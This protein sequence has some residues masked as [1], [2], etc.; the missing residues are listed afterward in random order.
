MTTP[1]QQRVFQANL[2]LVSHGLV[3]FTWGNAS[4]VD[5]AAGIML[6]KPSGVDYATLKAEQMVAVRLADGSLVDPAGLKPSSDTPTHLAMYR[7]WPAVGGIVHTHSEYATA[8]AQACTGI[9]AHGTTHA[10]YFH[11]D[12]PCTRPLTRREIEGAYEAD[13]GDVIVADFAAAG[14]D[15]LAVPAT[16]VSQHGPFAWGA[17]VEQAVYHATVLE[18]LARMQVHQRALNPSAP[19]LPQYL[20]D[21]H[22]QRK[23]GSNA[24][25]GQH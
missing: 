21:K 20:L 3:L 17:T 8:T 7:A 9:P 14:R 5:R 25:Y 23:H 12:I 19:L 1:L 15:P 6:I 18:R 2:D 24:Y 13:T 22:Y 11:G 4:A 16:L 10:D